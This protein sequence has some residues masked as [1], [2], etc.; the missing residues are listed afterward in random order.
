MDEISYCYALGKLI[1]LWY[2][3]WIA[4]LDSL[5]CCWYHLFMTD[6]KKSIWDSCAMLAQLLKY[7]INTKLRY[8]TWKISF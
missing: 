1:L 3:N 5:Y 4:R 6:L 7:C 2:N 8:F